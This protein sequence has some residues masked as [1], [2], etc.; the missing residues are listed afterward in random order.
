LLEC[1]P[2][3]ESSQAQVAHLVQAK[4]QRR[5]WLRSNP[6]Q[7]WQQLHPNAIQHILEGK[8]QKDRLLVDLHH[9]NQLM[10]IAQQIFH[11]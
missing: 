4:E 2:Y 10:L 1:D 3:K 6:Y 5:K 7:P 11:L 9:H 8:L